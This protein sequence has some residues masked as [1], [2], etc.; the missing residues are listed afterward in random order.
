M[1]I[2]SSHFSS[3]DLLA[4]KRRFAAGVDEEVLTRLSSNPA[5]HF[6]EK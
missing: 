2:S 1:A 6:P 5:S 3:M 4:P